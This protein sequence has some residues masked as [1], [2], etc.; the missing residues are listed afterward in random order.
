MKLWQLAIMLGF[1]G[2][3]GIC[4]WCLG[5]ETAMR[6]VGSWM[7]PKADEG[8]APTLPPSRERRFSAVD[9]RSRLS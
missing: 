8:D 7:K 5:Y 1:G 2:A 9:H 6:K 4:G 3:C